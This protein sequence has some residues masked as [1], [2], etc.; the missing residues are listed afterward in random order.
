[1]TLNQRCSE[2]EPEFEI[3]EES[4]NILSPYYLSSRYP[5]VAQFEEYSNKMAEDAVK[6][7]E[8]VLAFVKSKLEK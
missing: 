7:A 6:Q 4:C 1:M 3:L 8:R 5:D 2:T